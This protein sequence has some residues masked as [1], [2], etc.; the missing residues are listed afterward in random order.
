[1]Y[2][3]EPYIEEVKPFLREW[4]KEIRKRMDK[5]DQ[6]YSRISALKREQNLEELRQKGNTRVLEALMEDLM[7]VV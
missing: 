1:M 6:A 7:E 2:D 4:Q 5:Q 3:E